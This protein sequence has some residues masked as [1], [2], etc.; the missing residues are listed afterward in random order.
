M[1]GLLFL[2]SCASTKQ[3]EPCPDVSAQAVSAC[4]AAEKCRQA[5]RSYNFGLGL[6]VGPNLGIEDGQSQTQ[7]TNEYTKCIEKDMLEQK[8]AN[9]FIESKKPQNEIKK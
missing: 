2:L 4:R 6:G 1:G 8:T 3:K 5:K 7:N 9:E